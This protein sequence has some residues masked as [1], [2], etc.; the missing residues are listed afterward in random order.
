MM[1]L[2]VSTL[3]AVR[4]AS[5]G[6]P[7]GAKE[8]AAV[9]PVRSA[10]LRWLATIGKDPR[11]SLSLRSFGDGHPPPGLYFQTDERVMIGAQGMID[12]GS[13]RVRAM[14]VLRLDF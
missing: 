14:I 9:G 5:A 4:P 10:L 13:G 3:S 11:V 8:D 6:D 1:A 2:A 7:P 12:P